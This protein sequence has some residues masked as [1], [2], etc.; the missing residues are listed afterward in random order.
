MRPGSK[1]AFTYLALG[2]MLV[3]SVAMILGQ[4]VRRADERKQRLK[5]ERRDYLR[6]LRQT[7]RKVRTAVVE[8]RRALLWR[9]PE[10]DV[11]WSLVGTTR[12]WERRP[13]DVDFAE[14]RVA[15]R[16]DF[17]AT[18]HMIVVGDT[19]SGKTNLLRL[20][21]KAIMARYTP[22]EARSTPGP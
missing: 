14:V 6:Y 20:T 18:P 15:V 22:A 8:Q 5:G 9:H 3:S 1:G 16:H 19:E 4:F 17:S 13:G 10:P 12:L 11:L 7:R 21:A 2:L